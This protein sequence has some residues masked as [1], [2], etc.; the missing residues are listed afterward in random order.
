MTNLVKNIA[1]NTSYIFFSTFLAGVL[2]F[3]LNI[4]IARYLGEEI[5]GNY[6]FVIAYVSFFL[7][8]ANL[9]IDTL[10][11]RE[12]SKNKNL[13]EKYINN[14]ISMKMI[15]TSISFLLSIGII[16][17]MS[18][19]STVKLAV[20]FGSISLFFYAS[21]A[22]FSTY[23]QSRLEM[24]YVAA[25]N[26]L[27]KVISAAL[28]FYVIFTNG[29]FIKLIIA[30]SIGLLIQCAF[31]FLILRKR[32]NLKLKFDFKAGKVLLI[33]S[34][35][36]ALSGVF[37]LIYMRIDVVMI[38]LMKNATDVGIYSAAYNLTEAPV[39]IAGAFMITM[40]PLMSNYYKTSKESLKKAHKLSMKYMFMIAVPLAVGTTLL[41]EKII[42]LAYGQG[43]SKSYLPLSILIWSTALVFLGTVNGNTLI[44]TKRQN[45]LVFILGS[46][47]ILNIIMNLF[48][49]PKYSYVGASF[50]T[51]ITVMVV[52]FSVEFVLMTKEKILFSI[53]DFLKILVCSFVMGVMVYYLKIINFNPFLIVISAILTYALMLFLIKAINKEDIEIAKSVFRKNQ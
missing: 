19:D 12:I 26:I 20:L 25:S 43:F 53:K 39:L 38:S 36:F 5:F 29:G 40:L 23:F 22:I 14:S 6:S 37:T 16:L 21:I 8:L 34:L 7:I 30:A 15:L 33:E 9:G 48:L 13:T 42:L 31:L 4:I 2:T 46:A 24:I 49:I 3:F 45:T 28:I 17:S 44:A 50:A 10:V 18:Y 32:I 1:K 35:P 27:G 52:V 47:T 11:V 41:S 51:L